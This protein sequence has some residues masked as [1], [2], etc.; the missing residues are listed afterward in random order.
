MA[1]EGG[2]A[3]CRTGNSKF[4][5]K[6]TP[7]TPFQYKAYLENC[8]ACGRVMDSPEF[9]PFCEVCHDFL[10]PD[11]FAEAAKQ[12][13]IGSID[14]SVPQESES[15]SSEN[16]HTVREERT[17]ELN[18]ED[19]ENSDPVLTKQDSEKDGET[20]SK[21]DEDDSDSEIKSKV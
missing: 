2:S 4:R 15:N 20:S 16:D 14:L 6:I 10:Y 18:A 8:Q 3:L 1:S 21:S 9:G 19:P 17:E 13:R 5:R 11:A 12:A 7:S